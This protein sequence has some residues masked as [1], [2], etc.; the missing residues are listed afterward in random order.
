MNK[1]FMAAWSESGADWL[2]WFGM[3]M[4]YDGELCVCRDVDAVA[5]R[6]KHRKVML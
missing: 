2:S 3:P 5:N 6:N 4:L 1:Y